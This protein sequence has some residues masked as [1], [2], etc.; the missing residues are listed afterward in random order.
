MYLSMVY[1]IRNGLA[2]AITASKMVS[3]AV[4]NRVLL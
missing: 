2:G 1:D 3:S 4:K